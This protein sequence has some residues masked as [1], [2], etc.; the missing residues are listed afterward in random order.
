MKI[1][2]NIKLI[3]LTTLL[4]IHTDASWGSEIA[5]RT[6]NTK[7]IFMFM[8]FVASTLIITYWASKRTK[9]TNEFYAAGNQIS[10]L[11]NGLAVAGDYMSAATFLGFTALAFLVGFDVIFYTLGATV[12]W[13]I[14]FF[15]VA[16]R[17]RNLGRYT[18]ADAAAY[19]L[20]R[21]P[22]RT[23]S[24]AGTL[25]VVI[26]YLLAQMVGAGA[27]VQSLFNIPYVLAVCIVGGL[28]MLYVTFGGMLATTWVQII[29]AV[30]LLTGGTIMAVYVMYQFGFSFDALAREAVSIH[31][32][33]EDIMY[34]GGKFTD[35][36]GA[37]SLGMS[38]VFGTAG[39]P[40][41]LMRF[42]TVPNGN[43]A[44]KSAVYAMCIIGFFMSIVIIIGFGAVVFITGKP[45]FLDSDGGL[46][47]GANLAA[48]HLSY[49]I[50]GDYFLG[51]ISA[52]AFATI[53]AV[54]SG[55]SLSAASAV[56]HDLYATVFRN[57]KASEKEEMLVS[58]VTVVAIGVITVLLA[59]LFEKESVAFLA[60]LAL[61]IAASVNLPVLLLSM[62]WKNITTRG[63]VYGGAIGL[64]SAIILIVISPTIWVKILG[65]KEAIF[66]YGYPTIISMP[67]SFLAVYI[68]S[69][70]DKSKRAAN[71]R[72]AYET[73]VVRSEL[74][75]LKAQ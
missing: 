29:K 3:L 35:T 19:R 55:L 33:G 64:L 60:I 57:G 53:L 15:L 54:V 50:G 38:L 20:D 4:L 17:L 23:L 25:V 42:F 21:V 11:Q 69:I 7:A 74:G 70:T 26:P 5:E 67:I 58:R 66:P 24:A 52:V 46:I 48:V 65:Y 14:V 39:L 62:Y 13:V 44:R 75:N 37:L 34:P 1:L 40:H 28:M 6:T 30:L 72:A 12:A 41:I 71:E 63:A 49:V 61:A 16:E 27:L 18:F 8:L 32:K 9:S 56:S 59:I 10:A 22:I 31:S 36:W 45:E 68:F 73:Q 47:G 51:F 2:T 43:V